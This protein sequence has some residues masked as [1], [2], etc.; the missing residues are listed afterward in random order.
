MSQVAFGLDYEPARALVLVL[1]V[2]IYIYIYGVS[3]FRGPPK[4]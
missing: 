2:Y 4:K 1:G 3:V